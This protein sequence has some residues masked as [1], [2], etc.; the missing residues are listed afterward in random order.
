MSSVP[1][2][3][4]SFIQWRTWW[5]S[6]TA[7]T[8][9]IRG[10]NLIPLTY[11][12]RKHTVEDAVIQ[13]GPFRDTEQEYGDMYILQGAAYNADSKIYYEILNPL[14]IGGSVWTFVCGF[15]M[16]S[17]SRGGRGNPSYSTSRRGIS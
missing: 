10:V 5:E 16:I 1:V 7:Y 3:L 9:E 4:G 8:Q 12:H 2:V 11:I 15:D 17:N 6:W 13:A 14:L